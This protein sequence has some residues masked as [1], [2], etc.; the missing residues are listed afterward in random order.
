MHIVGYPALAT[1]FGGLLLAAMGPWR[2][3]FALAPLRWL[4]V[5]SYG[6]YVFHPFVV[7]AFRQRSTL[8]FGGWAFAAAAVAVSLAVAWLSYQ[9]YEKHWLALKRRFV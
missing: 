9:L 8:A 4:G 5:Y 7:R 2:T 6:I 1:A 3:V